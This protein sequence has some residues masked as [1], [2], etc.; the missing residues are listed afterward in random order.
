MIVCMGNGQVLE[1][2][3]HNDLIAAKGAYYALWRQ[4]GRRSNDETDLIGIGATASS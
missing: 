2:G 3:T 4:Q 1:I